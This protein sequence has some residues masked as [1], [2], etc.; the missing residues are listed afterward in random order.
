MTYSEEKQETEQN[1]EARSKGYKK[2]QQ[3]HIA[4]KPLTFCI[5]NDYVKQELLSTKSFF[6]RVG[7]WDTLVNKV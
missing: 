2:G 4:L 1:T 7:V 3:T 6:H 5:K